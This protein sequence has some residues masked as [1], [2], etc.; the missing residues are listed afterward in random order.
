MSSPS[1]PTSVSGRFTLGTISTDIGGRAPS[2][3]G[4][5]SLQHTAT[6]VNLLWT[7][8]AGFPVIFLEG[9]G[10][11]ITATNGSDTTLSNHFIRL[12][13]NDHATHESRPQLT[14]QTSNRPAPN[15]NPGPAPAAVVGV[16]AQLSGSVSNAINSAWSFVSGPEMVS[17]RNSVPPVTTVMFSA[18]A[19]CIPRLSAANS[20]GETSRTLSV[21]AAGVAL[22]NLETW[23]QQYFSTL[24]NTGNAADNADSNNDGENNLL[25]F[26]TGQDSNASNRVVSSL[27]KTGTVLEFT[28]TRSKAAVQDGVSFAV[29]YSDLLA[30]PWT[31]VGPGTVIAD[32]GTLETLRVSISS[33][34]SGRRFVRLRV[35]DGSP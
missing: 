13:S 5:L 2:A 7:P 12:A 1:F 24:S 20:F 30:P 11:G 14:I 6:G 35:S 28:Y 8:I 21:T 25:E 10:D 4:S 31:S 33:G 27:M 16:S 23:R 9:T 34:A 29:E 32:D 3:N 18:P 19:T 26:A 17:I 15:V 22:T